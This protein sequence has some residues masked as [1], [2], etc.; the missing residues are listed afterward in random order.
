MIYP[1]TRNP[2][3]LQSCDKDAT[4]QSAKD[5]RYW[6]LPSNNK[7]RDNYD[8]DLTNELHI[9]VRDTKGRE[10]K[11]VQGKLGGK[12]I[13]INT[14]KLGKITVSYSAHD[15]ANMFGK[16]G[17]DNANLLVGT[18]NIVDTA[19]PTIY[20]KKQG[21]AVEKYGWSRGGGLLRTVKA[22]SFSDCCDKC[23]TQQWKRAVGSEPKKATAK[24]EYFRYQPKTKKCHLH[25]TVAF[26]FPLKR[27]K[28]LHS[29]YPIQCQVSNFHE[30]KTKYTDPGARCIDFRD[31]LKKN[32]RSLSD[33]A[34]KVQASGNVL[35]HTVGRYTVAYTCSDRSKNKAAVLRRDI[36]VRDTKAPTIDLVDNNIL[37]LRAGFPDNKPY[38][39]RLM[40]EGEGFQCTD[41]CEASAISGP[42]QMFRGNCAGKFECLGKN[43]KPTVCNGG[44]RKKVTL[45]QIL[46]AGTWGVKY[47]C[48]DKSNNKATSKCRTIYM[49]VAATKTPTL[50]P[51]SA[52]TKHPTSAPT[53]KPVDCHVS[54]WG[55]W[56]VCSE[57]CG[58][59]VQKRTRSVITQQAHNGKQCPAQTSQRRNCAEYPCPINCEHEYDEWSLCTKVQYSAVQ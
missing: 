26:S 3:T 12:P 53:P 14:R 13:A 10:T 58:G 49:D 54:S 42:P 35:Q 1:K 22:D 20:C 6:N 5:R 28:G 48:A 51:T 18:I 32:G 11:Y 55:L 38:L 56:S 15:F 19:K 43:G 36:V 50:S 30:C 45:E 37:Q 47:S 7:V 9:T 34:L 52:P 21:C 25:A 29:G 46:E 16:N 8:G 31:S 59:G 39:Q 44:K 2:T 40:A 41:E 23:E 33:T 24:C 27:T 17:R 57:K 4:R